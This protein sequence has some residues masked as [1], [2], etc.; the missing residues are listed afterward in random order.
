MTVY[1]RQKATQLQVI[2]PKM[3]IFCAKNCLQVLQ[4]CRFDWINKKIHL[5]AS[6]FGKY[7]QWRIT[8]D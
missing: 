4:S 5:Q 2:K 6:G 7:N 1:Y 3:M 8:T